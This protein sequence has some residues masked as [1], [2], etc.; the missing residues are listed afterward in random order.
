MTLA[1]IQVI[2]FIFNMIQEGHGCSELFFFL[3]DFHKV[4]NFY[5]L[6]NQLTGVCNLLDRF[7]QIN[8]LPLTFTGSAILNVK[9]VPLESLFVYLQIGPRAVRH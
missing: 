9:Y 4:A 8:N 6:A 7:K 3:Q 5:P 2:Y 1:V